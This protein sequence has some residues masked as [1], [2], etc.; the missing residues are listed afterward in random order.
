M[1]VRARHDFVKG[2]DGLLY[3]ISSDEPDSKGWLECLV[4][5]RKSL[6]PILGMVQTAPDNSIT[7]L[8][9]TRLAKSQYNRIAALL[10]DKTYSGVG[11]MSTN[12]LAGYYAVTPCL[13]KAI[14][15]TSKDYKDKKWRQQNVCYLIHE[16]CHAA[17]RG[18]PED[19][20]HNIEF[21]RLMHIITQAAISLGTGVYDE[22]WYTWDMNANKE[23]LGG[24]IGTDAWWEFQKK[25]LGSGFRWQGGLLTRGKDPFV[26]GNGTLVKL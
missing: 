12:D 17:M 7:S 6:V 21:F 13:G 1:N 2:S 20:A 16:L 3:L 26:Q 23:A 15:L 10:N 9:D 14:F 11:S 5:L 25:T 18:P 4:N 24:W 19:V 8:S 22:K